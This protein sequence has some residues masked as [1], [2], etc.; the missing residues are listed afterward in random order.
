MVKVA[1]LGSTGMLGNAVAKH[2]HDTGY[3]V[4]TTYRNENVSFGD[5]K[6][7]YDPLKGSVDLPFECDYVINCIGVIKPFIED[8]KQNSI[9]LNSTFPRELADYCENTN[10]KLIHITTDCVFSGKE[11]NYSESS[12]HDCLDFYGKTKSLGEPENCMVIRTSIIG[13]EIHKNASLIAWVKSMKGQTIQGYTNHLWNGV[14][15]NQYAEIC[16]AIIN[17][18]LHRNGLYH[19]VSNKVNKYE[20]V[21]YINDRFNLELDIQ[22]FETDIV[23]DRTMSTETRLGKLLSSKL[24]TV[25]EQILDL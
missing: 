18:G 15:T 11:G 21:G 25:E 13:E 6:F 23:V 1:V 10:K 7:Y 17:D 19:L 14:T 5:N 4:I 20:L 16:Q 22:P 3:D 8:N 9:Y 2:L 24:K 12:D